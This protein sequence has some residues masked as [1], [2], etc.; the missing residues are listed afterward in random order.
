[1]YIRWEKGDGPL[2]VWA[3]PNIEHRY[4]IGAD[5][6]EGLEHGDYSDASV[7]DRNTGELV[8]KWH[9]H[10]PPDMFGEVL[11]N[12]GTWYNVALIGVESNNHGI[13]TITELRKRLRYPRLYRRHVVGEVQDRFTEKW[14]WPTNRQTKPLMIDALDKA[15]RNEEIVVYDRDTIAELRTY[16][17][18]EK[19]QLHGSPHDDRVM[20]LA[21]AVQ[22]LNYQPSGADDLVV[23]DN[24]GTLDWWAQQAQPTEVV[25]A[26]GAHNRRR[27]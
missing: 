16:V 5:V 13:S 26:I 22:M 2:Q 23:V 15:L 10:T 18:D 4:V 27:R 3:P 1:M 25:P 19:G 21:I 17:R 11:H 12:L 20:S 8:A 24:Y 7:L 9:G 14:G 6:A